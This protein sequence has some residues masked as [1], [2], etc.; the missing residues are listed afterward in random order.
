MSVKLFVG[1]LPHHVTSEDLEDLFSPVGE[2]FSSTVI[3][4]R[5]TGRSRGFGFVEMGSPQA[6]QAAIE[7]LHDREFEGRNL[8][9]NE[10]RPRPDR[11]ER[12]PGPGRG[13]EYRDRGR[14]PPR[15]GSRRGPRW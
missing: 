10:A 8:V 13:G 9:V 1:N 12:G 3:T 6:A 15:H 7:Q 11:F 4:D 14:R 2:V 5:A